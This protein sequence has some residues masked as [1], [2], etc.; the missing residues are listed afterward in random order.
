MYKSREFTTHHHTHT[1]THTHR[2]Y[3]Q[4]H[5]AEQIIA[6]KEQDLHFVESRAERDRLEKEHLAEEVAAIKS[7]KNVSLSELSESLTASPPLSRVS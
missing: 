7:T 6:E 2:D 4:L 1:H 3:A 5:L